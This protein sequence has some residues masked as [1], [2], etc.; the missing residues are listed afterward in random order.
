VSYDLEQY[1]LELL[2]PPLWRLQPTGAW[3]RER[4]YEKFIEKEIAKR[5]LQV[6]RP[7]L[8]KQVGVCDK[9]RDNPDTYIQCLYALFHECDVGSLPCNLKRNL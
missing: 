1:S 4:D 7:V 9:F 8:I 2:R 5:S 6:P 3:R